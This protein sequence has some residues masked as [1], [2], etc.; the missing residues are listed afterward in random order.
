MKTVNEVLVKFYIIATLIVM[1]FYVENGYFNTLDAKAHIF[2]A[3]SGV[4]MG[5]WA[6]FFVINFFMK[7]IA[8]APKKIKNRGK[9]VEEP[10]ALSKGFEFSLLDIAVLAFAAVSVISWLFSEYGDYALTGSQ[11]WNIGAWTI[12]ALAFTYFF[13]S[14]CYKHD[15][16]LV[17]YI[18]GACLVLYLLA[19]L[20]GL[21]ID[22]LAMHTKLAE[23]EHFEYIATI[24]N[25]NSYSGY[26]SLTLPV[27]AFVFITDE[28]KWLR[29]LAGCA[30]FLGVTNLIVDNSDGAFL[31]AGVAFMFLIYY[32]LKDGA[33]YKRMF[34]VGVLA[35]SACTFMMALVSALGDKMVELSGISAVV[36]KTPVCFGM[37]AVM[38]ILFF[39]SQHFEGNIPAGVTKALSIAFAVLCIAGIAAGVIYTAMHFSGKWGTKRGWI[40][41]FA[42]QVFAGGSIKDKLVGVGPECFGIPVMDQFSDFISEHWGKRIANA[43]NEFLQYLVTMGILGLAAY[44]M[45]YASA[46]VSYLK[47]KVKDPVM[48]ALFFAI[49]G[50]MGQAAVNNPQALNL[51][52]LF[53]FMGVFRAYELG[54]KEVSA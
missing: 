8:P 33:L 35:A 54:A 9:K 49:M 6:M 16:Y 1:P 32:C 46:F 51:A 28:R 19:L 27:I 31:G 13:V 23:S 42:L 40:W 5:A 22:P 38:I 26:L 43:H 15:N 17:V 34:A 24:G 45:T 7:M 44:V 18:I 53:V 25:I 41:G 3:A 20:N 4:L 10:E 29:I 11:G 30:V 39:V 36:T 48:L 2:W 47:T 50:Y 37:L 14:R 21:D 12:V 52:T